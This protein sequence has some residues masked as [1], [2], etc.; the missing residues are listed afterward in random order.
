MHTSDAIANG[1]LNDAVS[2]NITYPNPSFPIN[3][4]PTITPLIINGI[5][6]FIPV[7]KYGIEF[8]I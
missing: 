4:S 7:K 8:G 1:I 5:L 6:V 2:E 3:H